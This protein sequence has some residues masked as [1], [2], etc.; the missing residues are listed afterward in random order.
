MYL[1]SIHTGHGDTILYTTEE[2]QQK[3]KLKSGEERRKKKK[4]HH[5]VIDVRVS[6]GIRLLG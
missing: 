6:I 5:I 3:K 4:R 2:A 1:G